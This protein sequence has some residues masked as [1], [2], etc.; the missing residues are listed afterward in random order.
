MEL[1]FSFFLNG[2]LF[3][4]SLTS[5]L[6]I[7]LCP[8]MLHSLYPFWPVGYLSITHSSA[9]LVFQHPELLPM[10]LGIQKSWDG[11]DPSWWE[12]YQPK[13]QTEFSLQCLCMDKSFSCKTH[14]PKLFA[15]NLGGNP[16]GTSKHLTAFSRVRLI[17]S[18]SPFWNGVPSIVFLWKIPHSLFVKTM[19][20]TL[21]SIIRLEFFNFCLLQ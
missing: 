7:T 18:A 4:K 16:D 12:V 20:D 5:L 13:S 15:Q 11:V 19:A 6:T 3:S 8:S 17:L 2:N 21:L 9:L 14:C 1:F 10:L